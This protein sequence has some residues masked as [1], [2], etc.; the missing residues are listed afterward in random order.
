[1]LKCSELRA[2]TRP[3]WSGWANKWVLGVQFGTSLSLSIFLHLLCL[4][5]EKRG[6]RGCAGK[7]RDGGAPAVCLSTD[8]IQSSEAVHAHACV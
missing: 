7:E 8:G 4:T 1:M 6:K 3:D 5:H 2:L